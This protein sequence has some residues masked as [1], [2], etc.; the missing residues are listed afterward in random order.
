MIGTLVKYTVAAVAGA[1]IFTT[2]MHM[3]D[4]EA[5][6]HIR[7]L[8]VAHEALE[9]SKGLD[10]EDLKKEMLAF[11]HQHRAEWDKTYILAETGRQAQL[12]YGAWV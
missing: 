8:I 12:L 6:E 3:T 1:I 10:G 11:I 4:D 5:L 7:S 2:F 9:R